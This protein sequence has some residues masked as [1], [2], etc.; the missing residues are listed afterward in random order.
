[1]VIVDDALPVVVGLPGAAVVLGASVVWTTG[2]GTGAVVTG[3]L[4]TA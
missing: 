1:M 3:W 4:R 2:G